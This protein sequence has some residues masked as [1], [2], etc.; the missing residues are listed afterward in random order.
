[1]TEKKL[2]EANKLFEEI[3]K[4]QKI[5]NTDSIE[6]C[7]REKLTNDLVYCKLNEDI[8]TDLRAFLIGNL[9]KLERKFEVL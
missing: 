5:L 4:L 1:M 8:T 6:I 7:G 2:D 9:R 3:N